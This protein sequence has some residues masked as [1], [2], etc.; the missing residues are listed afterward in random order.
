MPLGIDEYRLALRA[1]QAGFGLPDRVALRRMCHTL[2]VKSPSENVLFSNHFDSVMW[3]FP[4]LDEEHQLHEVDQHPI[5]HFPDQQLVGPSQHEVK[6]P[7]EPPPQPARLPSQEPASI[8]PPPTTSLSGD[9]PSMLSPV[10]AAPSDMLRISD[11]VQ[12]AR[13]VHQTLV[14]T[15]EEQ[16]RGS[17]MSVNDYFPITRRQMKQTWR[18]LR[19]PVREGAPAEL[20][21]EATIQ[22]V[23]RQGLMIAPVLVPRRTNR[24]R[25]MLLLDQDGSMVPFHLLSQRLVDTASRGGRLDKADIFY[26]HNCPVDYVYRDVANQR[27]EQIVQ[28]LQKVHPTRT[29]MLIFSDAGA[30]RGGYNAKRLASTARFLQ[31][32]KQHIRYVAWLNPLPRDRW[33]GTTAAEI[34]QLVP[35]FDV[36]RHGLDAAVQVLRGRPV[37][38]QQK[39]DE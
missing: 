9:I 19:H 15:N 29:G 33:K 14:A 20:D 13:A 10:A 4:S 3:S 37:Q 7:P 30:A 28:L 2:W 36:S 23:G 26:F 8:H 25:L 5:E 11:E 6:L 24:A 16:V 35:M 38:L 17:F 27:D 34:A 12:I 18:Y 39:Y 32:L 22:E 21:V 31:L 1:L